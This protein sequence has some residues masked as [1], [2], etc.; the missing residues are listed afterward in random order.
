VQVQKH[1]LIGA[2]TISA[3]QLFETC[4]N[5]QE[6][7]VPLINPKKQEKSKKYVDSGKIIF[8]NAVE[9]RKPSQMI[10]DCVARKECTFTVTKEDYARQRIW[11]CRDCG[12]TDEENNRGC[13][14]VCKDTCHA[15]HDVFFD[16]IEN[17]FC[18]CPVLGKCK[19]C[20]YH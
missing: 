13:C 9:T 7:S 20:E 15:G 4:I 17:F 10:L 1:E 18:D 6:L 3:K 14:D 8:S 2:C 16:E 12:L 11:R 19:I 5:G